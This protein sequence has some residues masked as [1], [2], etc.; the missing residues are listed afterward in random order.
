MSTI[1]YNLLL[2]LLFFLSA[3]SQSIRPGVKNEV[4]DQQLGLAKDL[5]EKRQIKQGIRLLD[6]SSKIQTSD[7]RADLMLAELHLNVGNYELANRYY[8]QANIK[9]STSEGLLGEG[10]TLLL[11]N[12]PKAAINAYDKA[13]KIKSNSSR[14]AVLGKAVALDANGQHE[15]ARQLYTELIAKDP[16]DVDALNNYALSSAFAG[17]FD[18][19][20]KLT[21]KL[22]QN[23]ADNNEYKQNLALI[24]LMAG[25]KKAAWKVAKRDISRKEFNSNARIIERT[26][27]NRS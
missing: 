17:N 6:K 21:E 8:S 23:E 1:R 19:A 2:T 11:L 24:H 16:G 7:P 5:I 4:A 26:F 25:D 22:I 13:I 3:C 10:K 12:K 9:K 18:R 20:I 27:L 15:D 14:K